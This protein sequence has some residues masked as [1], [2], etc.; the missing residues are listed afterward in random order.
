MLEF[1][2]LEVAY[3]I[4]IQ[5]F[6]IMYTVQGML[7]QGILGRSQNQSDYCNLDPVIRDYLIIVNPNCSTWVLLLLFFSSKNVTVHLIIN[8]YFLIFITY[9]F[10]NLLML[11]Q[12]TVN[13]YFAVFKFNVVA[14]FWWLHNV[15]VQYLLHC[16]FTR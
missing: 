6:E 8:V 16:W 15:F 2:F 9:M 11:G 12:F 14:G 5:N 13:Y 3:T 10:I 7:G 1:L 4:Y